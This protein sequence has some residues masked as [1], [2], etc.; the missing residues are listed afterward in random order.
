MTGVTV[1][2]WFVGGGIALRYFVLFVGV[3]SCMYAL[4]D[5]VGALSLPIPSD[6]RHAEYATDDTL[7]RKVNTSD[8]SVFADQF[9]CCPSRVWGFLWLV[10]SL[11]FFA[12]G[13][14]VGLV[15]FKVTFSSLCTVGTL[16][17]ASSSKT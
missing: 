14:L 9:G 10:I 11:I 16:A 17:D 6:A 5:I 2:F 1:L 7:A 8:A 15:A 12:L 13:V 3:M 4:W